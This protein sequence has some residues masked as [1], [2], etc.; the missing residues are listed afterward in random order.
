M[1]RFQFFLSSLI[2]FALRNLCDDTQE[3]NIFYI[4]ALFIFNLIGVYDVFFIKKDFGE[5]FF[6]FILFKNW[7]K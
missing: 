4:I 5:F 2:L 7:F 1:N 6:D 3:I